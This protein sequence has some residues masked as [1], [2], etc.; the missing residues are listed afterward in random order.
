MNCNV[1]IL[2]SALLVAQS[3]ASGG[4]YTFRE[5]VRLSDPAPDTKG[6]SFTGFG[7]P[8]INDAGQ[9]AFIAWTNSNQAPT[10]AWITSSSDPQSISAIVT[11]G[12]DAPG[13]PGVVDFGEFE[14]IYHLIH[15]ANTGDVTISA[16]LTGFA[17]PNTIGLYRTLNGVLTKIAIPG[18]VAPGTAGTGIF[19]EITNLY[20]A[21][22]NGQVAFAAKMS[23]PGV[24]ES[25]DGAVFSQS[26]FGLV[27]TAREG[28]GAPGIPGTTFYDLS[29]TLVLINDQSEVAF[30]CGLS[31]AGAT[32]WS[33][34]MG[35]P[36][37]LQCVVREGELS[38][39][40]LPFVNVL[41]SL[42]AGSLGSSHL[43]VKGAV[44][45][46]GDLLPGIW[47]A[48]NAQVETLLVE[49]GTAPIG[50]YDYIPV[51]GGGMCRTDGMTVSAGRFD[52]P[53][54][55]DTID[56]ALILSLT[57]G[58][59]S[60]LI[61]EGDPVQS[62]GAGIFHD[63][64]ATGPGAGLAFPD[65]HD[66]VFY[67]AG[68]RGVGV[69]LSNDTALMVLNGPDFADLVIREGQTITLGDGVPRQ[70][71]SYSFSPGAGVASGFRPATNAHGDVAMLVT[72]TDLSA[73]I[74]VAQPPL[75]C[76]GDV[77]GDGLVNFDDLLKVLS[78]WAP[79]IPLGAG[80]DADRD[81]DVDFEDLLLVLGNW[82]AN[83]N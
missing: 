26:L 33:N 24:L 63:D 47:R 74:V 37:A 83:C 73:A 9:V 55:S 10:G 79:A 7:S 25:N 78:T 4:Q 46:G 12:M 31:G 66:R 80:G 21:N 68:L 20:S 28:G 19:Q 75:Y 45:D 40:G 60:I 62:V 42:F 38:D 39:S 15:L 44:D 72:F 6:G 53:G 51:G 3:G 59:S 17:E 56:S 2:G 49:G 35:L 61:R 32:G 14:S 36:G 11:E 13:A 43:V 48:D 54:L 70:V 23:G 77:T 1:A 64:F 30:R 27:M 82:G 58:P 76:P 65:D 5:I 52:A 18:D 16:P 69:N 41:Y 71:Q 8:R 34:W 67:K 29:N 22:A 57:A 50:T 81:G